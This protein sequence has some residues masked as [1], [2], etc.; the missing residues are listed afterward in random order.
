MLN[1]L[2]SYDCNDLRFCLDA[3]SFG[4]AHDFSDYLRRTFDTLMREGQNGRPKM[5]SIGLHARISGKPGRFSAVREFADYI[6]KQE[7]V[8][9]TTRR[10][11]AKHFREQ[12]P[13]DR[14]RGGRG[15]RDRDRDGRHGHGRVEVDVRDAGEASKA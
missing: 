15:D 4:G 9:V 7:G 13:Y 1:N 6:S 12:F 11:V 2:H 8:W 14:R 10:E 3:G 5:M